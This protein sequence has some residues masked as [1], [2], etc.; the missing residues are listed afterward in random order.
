MT[1]L[2]SIILGIVQ[3]LTEFLPISS[4]GH[5]VILPHLLG[6]EIPAEQIFPFDVLV[7]IGTLIAVIIY[8]RQDIIDILK[9]LIGDIKAK[10]LGA[11]PASR[12]GWFLVIATIPAGLAGI[13]LKDIVEQAFGS[14]NAAAFFLF[15]TALL[16]ILAEVISKKERDILEIGWLDALWIGF[17]QVM[18]LFPGLSRS[19][20]CIAGGMTRDLDRE[21][22]GRFSFLMAIP[23]MAAAGLWGIFDLLK[24]PNLEQF[25]PIMAIGFIVAGVVGYISI[26][27]LLKFVQSHSLFIF[28]GYCIFLGVAVLTF[29][30]LFPESN[31]APVP[32]AAQV[33]E[34]IFL[35]DSITYIPELSWLAP[36]AAECAKNTLEIDPPLLQT[37]AGYTSG[38]LRFSFPLTD[39][40]TAYAFQL[41]EQNLHFVLNPAN[42]LRSLDQA[43][44]NLLLTGEYTTWM[45]FFQNCVSCSL[46]DPYST[47]D[48]EIQFYIYPESNPYQVIFNTALNIN[49]G[50]VENGI[51]IPDPETLLAQL[52]LAPNAAG[53]LPTRWLTPN[54]TQVTITDLPSQSLQ[55]PILALLEEQP[56]GQLEQFLLCVQTSLQ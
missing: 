16:L 27:W 19:G 31:G 30:F 9:A 47:F 15:G 46:A 26:A 56:H 2:Q 17:F 50:Q 45:Q 42:P 23:V 6:W 10:K 28:A 25:I 49:L 7:Q 36:T 52:Q 3:G 5:L 41:G 48:S 51:F 54:L 12:I 33:E 1:I 53:I 22:A 32:E 4:S 37:S 20:S 14:P 18:A 44:L 35:P 11:S 34:K 55:L 13:L 39:Q 43:D 29:G 21:S 38:E 24:V 8:F 40:Q